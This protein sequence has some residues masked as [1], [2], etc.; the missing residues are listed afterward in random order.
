MKNTP[1]GRTFETEAEMS[2]FEHVLQQAQEAVKS[3]RVTR[4][5]AKDALKEAS[6]I[7][8]V[9]ADSALEELAL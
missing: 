7:V 3:R 2:L 9:D 8:F 5:Q 4:K 1:Y 6:T